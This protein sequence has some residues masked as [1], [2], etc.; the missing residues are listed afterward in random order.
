MTD[1]PVTRPITQADLPILLA[2]NNAAVPDVNRLD[3]AEL[4]RLA[5]LSAVATVV[6]LDGKPQGIVLALRPG[7]PYDSLNYRWFT[8]RYEDFLYVDRV[9]VAPD[10]RGAGLGRMLY[11]EVFDHAAAHGVARVTCEVNLEPRNPVRCASTPGWSIDRHTASGRRAVS[12][13]QAWQ[14]RR[15]AVRARHTVPL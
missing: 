4:A 14:A 3:E 6:V 13:S 8:E 5:D 1:E 9:I 12:E 10:R 15:H 7:R 2:M 11:A